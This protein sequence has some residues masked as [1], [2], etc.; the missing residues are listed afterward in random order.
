MRKIP[1]TRGKVALVD[2]ADY[3]RINQW[4]WCAT[5]PYPGIFYATRGVNHDQKIRT[6]YMHR[7]ILGLDSADHRRVDHVNG[8]GLDN[9]RCNLRL[10]TTAENAM[11]Q[12]VQ[13][14]TKKHSQYKGVTW[15]AIRKRWQANIY[16]GGKTV[17]L[18]Y[19]VNEVDAAM[20]YNEAALYYF[21]EFARLNEIRL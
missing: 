11:N 8:N 1:L 12:R 6:V 14:H 19:F 18:G 21:G 16:L 10:A 9:R 3:E 5:N 15:R 17:C 20:A 13:S 4:K 7:A 2:D